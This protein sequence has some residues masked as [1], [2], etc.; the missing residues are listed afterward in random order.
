MMMMDLD[1]TAGS[2]DVS[3]MFESRASVCDTGW[4]FNYLLIPTPSSSFTARCALL[5]YELPVGK[6]MVENEYS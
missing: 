4:F 5:Q 2:I 1:P 6:I 3:R